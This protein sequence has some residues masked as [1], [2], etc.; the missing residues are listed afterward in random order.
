MYN[1]LTMQER[2]TLNIFKTYQ[3]YKVHKIS[4][5]RMGIFLKLVKFYNY[6]KYNER[7]ENI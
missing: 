5:I 4:N 2:N 7:F 6:I 3:A 1:V